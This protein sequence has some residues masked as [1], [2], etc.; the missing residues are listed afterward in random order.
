MNITPAMQQYYNLKKQYEDCILFFRMGDFYEMFEDDAKIAHKVLWIALTTRNKNAENPILLAGIPFHAK[1]KY[2]PLLISAGYKIALAEQ[3]SDPKLKGIVKR[4]VVR[5]I[6]PATLSLEE[7]WYN[8]DIS[9]TLICL[10]QDEDSFGMSILDIASHQWKCSEFESF[11]ACM[12]ELYKLSP[13][14]VILEKQ[15]F[16]ESQIQEILGKKYSLNIYYYDFKEKPYQYL[17]SRFGT[18]NLE[19]YGLEDKK[20]AQKASATL[21]KYIM[22]NQ[23]SE[24]W[25]IQNLRYESYGK[26]MR[27]DESTIRSLDLIYNVAIASKNEGTLF[28]TLNKTKTAMGKRY[29]REQILQPLQDVKEIKKRQEFIE[30]FKSNTIFLDKIRSEL[31]YIAD[32]DAIL[33][34]LSIGRAG[35]RDLLSLKKSLISVKNVIELI[36]SS[37]NPKLK[38]ILQ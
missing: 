1:E 34:R 31:N 33:S 8:S 2:L 9:S 7:E 12:S 11:D 32:L 19:W 3:V 20:L 13:S 29:L 23:K 21:L 36:E 14:E 6:T 15:L 22:E 26:Y 30:I 4:E 17:K 18:K 5:V 24:L 27:L 16:W 38:K 35:P 10:V 37:E 25:F 28:W